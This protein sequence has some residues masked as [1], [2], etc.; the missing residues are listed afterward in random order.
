METKV[1]IQNAIITIVFLFVLTIFSKLFN[2]NSNNTNIQGATELVNQSI[3]LKKIASQD[4]LPFMKL[5]HLI[6][7]VTYIQAARH[8]CKDSDIEKQTGVDLRRLK[9]AIDDEIKKVI[10]ELNHKFPKLKGKLTCSM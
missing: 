8:V 6:S 7:S 3:K 5:Q 4:S 10:E 1:H 2:E 9:R